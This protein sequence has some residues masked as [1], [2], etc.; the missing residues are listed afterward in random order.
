MQDNL[1][2]L[3]SM[4]LI[5]K[6]DTSGKTTKS[7]SGMEINGSLFPS[8]TSQPLMRLP[9]S[10]HGIPPFLIRLSLLMQHLCGRD[11]TLDSLMKMASTFCSR[12]KDLLDALIQ[13][14]PWRAKTAKTPYTL[15][16]TPTP[17]NTR[18]LLVIQLGNFLTMENYTSRFKLIKTQDM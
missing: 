4:L 5:A 7:T 3:L 15:V 18:P 14:N 17:I 16:F 2:A 6:L 12:L 9:F 10:I 13:F 1:K 11:G 8:L